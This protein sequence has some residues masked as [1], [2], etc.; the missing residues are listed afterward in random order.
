MAYSKLELSVLECRFAVCRLSPRSD[1]PGWAVNDT[2]FSITRTL[3]ELS[4]ICPEDRVPE[5]EMRE[6]G[7]RCLKVKGPLEFSMIGAMASLAAPLA[8]A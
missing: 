2:F 8:E 6:V 7:W 4:I 3:E 1:L 5:G